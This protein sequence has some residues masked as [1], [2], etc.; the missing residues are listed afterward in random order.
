MMKIKKFFIIYTAPTCIVATISFFMTYL[1]H[2]MTQD[3]WME[4]A[5]AL[6]VSLCVIL[7]IVGFMLQN[8]GQFVAKRFIGF[9][10]LTQKL[11]QCL[12]IALSI[13]SI[14]S[15]IA[16]ITT[17]QSDSVFMFLQIWLMTLLKALPLGY[18]IGMMMV[19]V[20]KPRM[21]KALSKLAT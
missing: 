17:A 13:E 7:P 3:F 11:V 5:K 6:C 15:L 14:L 21:Q 1:N 19:F 2:G 10:L 9:S 12:L 18:V 16:T 4:W 8:I 20:V